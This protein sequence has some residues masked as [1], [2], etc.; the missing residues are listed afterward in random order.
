M[1]LE[2]FPH[3]MRANFP[4]VANESNKDLI[5]VGAQFK[6]YLSK[7]FKG[8]IDKLEPIWDIEIKTVIMNQV[9][10]NH[11]TVKGYHP[12]LFI[13]FDNFIKGE[14]IRLKENEQ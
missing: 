7:L 3:F 10:N 2:Y 13:H 5:K 8:K 14:V 6:E 1:N 12:A 9:N 11:F 4:M